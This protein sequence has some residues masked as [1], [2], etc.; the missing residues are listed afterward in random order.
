MTNLRKSKKGILN[1]IISGAAF[2]MIFGFIIIVLYLFLTN[3]IT[4][5]KTTPQWDSATMDPVANKYLAAFRIFDYIMVMLMVA[6][7][8]GTVVISYRIASAPLYFVIVLIGSAFLGMISYF[9]SYM[10]Q[11]MV[12]PAVFIPVTKYFTRTILICTNLHWVALA[13][14]I[15]GSITMFGK[16]ERG[17]YLG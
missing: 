8:V 5:F 4:I 7:I 6:L 14:L 9:F 11:Q 13:T 16:R 15:L 17:Q 10:F 2:L 3:Y 1:D 12:S